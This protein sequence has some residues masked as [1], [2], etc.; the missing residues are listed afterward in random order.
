VLT[1]F[2]VDNNFVSQAYISLYV[3]RRPFRQVSLWDYPKEVTQIYE[4]YNKPKK[5]QKERDAMAEKY[6]KLGME[7][8]KRDPGKFLLWRVLKLFY[9]WEKHFLF[10]Y[11]GP[12]DKILNHLV[13]W[14]N[15]SLLALGI[16]GMYLWYR[17]RKEKK[18]LPFLLMAAFLIVFIS[19]AHIFSTADE[20]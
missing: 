11:T 4:E 3:D 1:P 8:I 2:T 5:S 12:D 13:Y 10:W 14:S 20:R 17:I 19:F 7:E 6:R 16:S 9:V 15:L 18:Y